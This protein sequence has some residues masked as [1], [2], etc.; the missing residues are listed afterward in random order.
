MAEINYPKY[1]IIVAG[2]S[3]SRMQSAVPKQFMAIGG[4]PVLMH[5][6]RCFARF[7]EAVQLVVVLPQE[8]VSVWQAL[9]TQHGFRVA[10]SIVVGGNSRFQSVKNGLAALSAAQDGVVAVH[11]GV[12]PLVSSPILADAFKTAHAQGSAVVAVPLK[13]SIRCVEGVVSKSV[14][15]TAYR[16][17]QTPQCFRL[18][19]LRNAYEQ[20][21]STFFTDDASVVEAIGHE[22]TLVAGSYRNLKITTPEDLILAETLLQNKPK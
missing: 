4:E 14:D 6:I 9:C 19:V 15:R 22:I 16:L 11:D 3:G 5:T 7:D 8:Q 17:V 20:P 12:R 1:A 13:D 21:E 10:H 18:A 2:G